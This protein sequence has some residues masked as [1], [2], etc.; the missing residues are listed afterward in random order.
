MTQHL[1]DVVD[2]ADV[3][4]EWPV[5]DRAMSTLEKANVP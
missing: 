3:A 4:A 5:A 1:G 2:Q